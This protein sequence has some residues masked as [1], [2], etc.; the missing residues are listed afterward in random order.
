MSVLTKEQAAAIVSTLKNEFNGKAYFTAK[1]TLDGEKVFV[2]HP[3]K[4]DEATLKA[5]EA[6]ANAVAGQT[7]CRS[8][9]E[10]KTGQ[11]TF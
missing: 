11:V 9:L 5:I 10:F 4:A 6:R 3:R 8:S 1:T 7:L 2:F